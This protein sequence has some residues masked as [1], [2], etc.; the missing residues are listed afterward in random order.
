VQVNV[1][2]YLQ[3]SGQPEQATA[4]MDSRSMP[5][6]TRTAIVTAA[7]QLAPESKAAITEEK[8][9]QVATSDI[10]SS[11]VRNDSLV[12]RTASWPRRIPVMVRPDPGS[13][14]AGALP[15]AANAADSTPL[16]SPSGS[17][18]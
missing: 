10:G 5:P 18:Q 2:L 13:T 3:A 7:R 8:P 15:A 16:T 1:A 6:A 12:L 14:D 11:A 9:L 4:L 17:T